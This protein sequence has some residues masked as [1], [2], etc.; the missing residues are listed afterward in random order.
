M[1]KRLPGTRSLL[2]HCIYMCR[3]GGRKLHPYQQDGLVWLH[4]CREQGRSALLADDP[5]LGKRVQASA[6]LSALSYGPISLPNM[7]AGAVRSF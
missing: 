5:G 7:S 6:F 4:R 3:S 2:T 1:S